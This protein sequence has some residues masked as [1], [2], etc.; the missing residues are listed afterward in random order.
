MPHA[1]SR[2]EFEWEAAPGNHVLRTRATD[3]A[4]DTQ[5]LDGVYNEKGYLLNA[6][7]PHPVEVA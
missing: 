2:F 6:V 4:G 7:L 1:W 5:P 3:A